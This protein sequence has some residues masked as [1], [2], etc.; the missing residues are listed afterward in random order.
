MTLL[1]DSGG[2]T[3]FVQG[4]RTRLLGD[5]PQWLECLRGLL[6]PDGIT[7]ETLPESLTSH[8]SAQNGR[9][10]VEV[11]PAE[12]VEENQALRRFVSSVQQKNARCDRCARDHYGSRANDRRRLY[13]SD[14][15]GD[16]CVFTIAPHGPSTPWRNPPCPFAAG[17][18]APVDGRHVPGGGYSPEFGER[19]RLAAR[20]RPGDCLRNLSDPAATGKPARLPLAGSYGAVRLRLCCLV[21]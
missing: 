13:P 20:A 4:L 21:P 3:L 2:S 15:I 12:N 7:L 10:R 11:F 17:L 8:Y 14:H 1:H 18:D 6:A 16:C 19:D 5:F 9:T